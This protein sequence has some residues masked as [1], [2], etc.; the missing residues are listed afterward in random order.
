MKTIEFKA[1][2]GTHNVSLEALLSS[3]NPDQ[4]P[5][6]EGLLDRMDKCEVLSL[7][8]AN[9]TLATVGLKGDVVMSALA[10]N[11]HVVEFTPAAGL[12]G[13][14]SYSRFEYVSPSVSAN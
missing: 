10:K 13:G 2:R 5:V 9:E 12:I 6:V 4:R 14:V 3:V 1:Y 7:T 8:D 11:G